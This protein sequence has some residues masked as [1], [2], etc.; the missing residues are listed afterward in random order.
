VRPGLSL[1]PSLSL[2]RGLRLSPSLSLCPNLSL[3]PSPNLKP[4]ARLNLGLSFRGICYRHGRICLMG[5]SW[6]NGFTIHGGF[7]NRSGVLQSNAGA[8]AAFEVPASTS[9]QETSPPKNILY[10][11]KRAAVAPEGATVPAM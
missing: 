6:V 5:L 3:K 2:R 4:R 11:L 10:G 9:G 8:I 7:A 1:S